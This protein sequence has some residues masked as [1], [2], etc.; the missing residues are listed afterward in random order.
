MP[1]AATAMPS[2]PAWQDSMSTSPPAAICPRQSRKKSG[3][4][5]GF[6]NGT[7]SIGYGSSKNSSSSAEQSTTQV[8]SAIAS[9]EGGVLINAGNQLTISASDVAA[10]KDLT[11]VGKDINLLA[12]QDTTDTQSSQSSKS[13]GFSVGVTYDPAKAYRTARANAP[14]GLAESGTMMGRIT[15]TA[16]GPALEQQP[17]PLH[18]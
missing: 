7:A 2:A 18:Q 14:E 9:R 16:E 11:L 10:G 8:G 3:F 12:R 15:R 5:G 17:E 4:T 1:K 6:S 13:S